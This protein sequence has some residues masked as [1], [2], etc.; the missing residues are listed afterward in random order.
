MSFPQNCQ[1]DV[2]HHF[3]RREGVWAPVVHSRQAQ[4]VFAL[5]GELPIRLQLE[6]QVGDRVRRR[7]SVPWV[8]QMWAEA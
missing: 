2:L 3:R 6:S 5:Q 1:D 4:P 7:Y 8:F